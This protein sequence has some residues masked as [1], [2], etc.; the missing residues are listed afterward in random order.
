LEE[1][2]WFNPRDVRL[3]L[4]RLGLKV[5]PLQNVVR[6]G[7]IARI[8]RTENDSPIAPGLYQWNETVRMLREYGVGLGWGRNN[9]NGLPTIINPEGT[10]A[11]CVSSGDE[12]TGIAT[13]TPGTKHKKGPRTAA[14][15]TSNQMQLALGEYITM[16][17]GPVYSSVDGRA[18][19]T[20]TLLFFPDHESEEIR[21]ELSLPIFIASGDINGWSER[22]ILPAIPLD[23]GDGFKRMSDPDF[24]PDVD[25]DIRRLA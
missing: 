24:G 8:S 9:D 23:G 22:I 20:W 1:A 15:V 7:Y 10:I 18:L 4:D 17:K 16:Q 11:I 19:A 2:V 13:A 25:I 14:F 5:D 21:S 6:G 3:R 12:K